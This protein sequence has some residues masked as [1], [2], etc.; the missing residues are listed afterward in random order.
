MRKITA[1]YAWQ[2][3]TPQQFNRHLIRTA[4]EEAAQRISA[5]SSLNVE[6]LI[7]SDTEGVLGQPPVTVTILAKIDSCDIFVPDLTFVAC[8]DGGKLIPNPNVMTEYGYALR[9]KT[10]AAMM[11]VMNTAFGPPEKLP[12]DMGHLRHPV[13]YDVAPT[14]KDAERR[15]VGQKL[16]ETLEGILRLYVAGTQPAAPTPVLFPK[17]QAQDGPAR[18]RQAAEPIGNRWDIFP[19]GR[20][21][22][23][24]VSMASGAA[25]WLRVMPAFDPGK[26]WA[27]YE[28]DQYAIHNN[29][30]NLAP[31][32]DSSIFKLRAHDGIG[33]CS[34]MAPD[35]SETTSVAFAFETGEVWGIDTTLLHY[36]QS[37][38]PFLEPYYEKNLK[39]YASFLSCLGLK[40]PYH[41][42][43]G[44]TGVRGRRLQVP[45]Q[46]GS[47]RI[48]GWPGPQ[49]L[50]DTIV[51][52][53]A[54]DGKQTPTSALHPFFRT[55]FARCGIPRPD[56]LPH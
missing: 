56:D 29:T 35:D 50:A 39:L 31:F 34:L 43:C 13:Q 32:V 7:D 11:P 14:A 30:L 19:I 41:W 5:D 8:T 36:S 55:I 46:S 3:D 47:V 26:T 23:G 54:Y 2:S 12:F 1:F 51:E 28:L 44:I 24:P 9:A 20:Y 10:H 53:G 4:L 49:C 52:E 15:E 18:F 38:L 48:P 33:I 16:S 17:A 27:S 22:D 6:I 37:D 42:V 45:L 21:S 40:P 25:M